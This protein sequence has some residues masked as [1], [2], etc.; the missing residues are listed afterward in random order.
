LLIHTLTWHHG[1]QDGQVLPA[2]PDNPALLENLAAGTYT[3]VVEQTTTGCTAV[4]SFEVGEKKFKNI[5][6]SYCVF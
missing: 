5:L 6:G 3:V 2:S 4:E 1:D